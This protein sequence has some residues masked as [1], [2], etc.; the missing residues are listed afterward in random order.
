MAEARGGYKITL[1]LRAFAEPR[2]EDN[3]TGG[4]PARKEGPKVTSFNL[5]TDN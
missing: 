4:E 5:H 2:N 1:Y 3:N